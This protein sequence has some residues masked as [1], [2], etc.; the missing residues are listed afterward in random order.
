MNKRGKE[1][2]PSW[3]LYILVRGDRKEEVDVLNK[4]YSILEGGKF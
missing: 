3:S 2:Q 1:R 4:L